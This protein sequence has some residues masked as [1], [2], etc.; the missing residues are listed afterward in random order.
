MNNLNQLK[1]NQRKTSLKNRNILFKKNKYAYK[2][3]FNYLYESKIFKDSKVI[4]SY[5]S[6]N[7]EIQTID[8][9]KKILLLNKPL[10]LPVIT[11]RKKK[12]IF[13]KIT[14]RTKMIK[15][16][17][18]L[19]EPSINSKTIIPDLILAP[20]VAFDKYGNRLGYGGG[21]YDYTINELRR[22]NKKLNLIVVGFSDQEVEKIIVN[23]NDQKLDYI[24]TEKGLIKRINK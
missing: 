24:L 15:G 11:E 1:L 14:K 4:S 2:K 3:L 20:C 5:I 21:Y 19:I 22:K 12:L 18:N 7:S 13:K 17:M 23:E 10:C 8:L 9:N 6:I 16:K